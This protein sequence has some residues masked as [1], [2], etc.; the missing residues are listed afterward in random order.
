MAKAPAPDGN[1]I[2]RLLQERSQYLNWLARLDAA[3]EGG[4]TVPE[5]VRHRVRAD[6]ESRLVA[7]VDQLRAHSAAIAGQLEALH[8]R[9]ADLSTRE[10]AAKERMSEAEVR[11][12]VG[13]YDEARWQEIRNEQTKVLGS[14]REEL[15]RTVAEIERLT[16][17]QGLVNAPEDALAEPEPEPEPPPLPPQPA[18]RAGAPPPPSPP[19]DLPLLNFEPQVEVASQPT[20]TEQ[21]IRRVTRAAP[22]KE[23]P[24]ARTEWIPSEK[25]VGRP[26]APK[27]DELA[28]LK[29][30]APEKS[31]PK[32]SSGGVPRPPEVVSPP[33]PVIPERAAV[34]PLQGITRADVFTSKAQAAIPDEPQGA[35]PSGKDR[36]SQQAAPKTLKCGECGTLN[37][38]T[39]WYCERCG[40]ELAAL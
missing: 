4:A 14:T 26:A 10:A 12:A 7:V 16:E 31:A 36:P 25:P 1:P 32:R 22:R 33:A 11:H 39:E 40:A 13:E 2:E 29:S 37:R 20:P 21:D 3:G 30:V 23:E 5:A 34:E 6:Y 18:P 19:T 9:Q 28:F 38:P 35:S 15:S 24:P 27:I 8:A 17:V